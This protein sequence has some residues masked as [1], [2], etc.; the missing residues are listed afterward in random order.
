M[1]TSKR[2]SADSGHPACA[3]RPARSKAHLPSE[4]W[5]TGVSGPQHRPPRSSNPLL[6]VCTNCSSKH[7]WSQTHKSR[8]EQ[9]AYPWQADVCNSKPLLPACAHACCRV[10]AWRHNMPEMQLHVRATAN[11]KWLCQAGSICPVL[12]SPWHS[13][14]SEWILL[15]VSGMRPVIFKEDCVI[16]SKIRLEELA[17]LGRWLK[18]S[19]LSPALDKTVCRLIFKASR[20]RHLLPQIVRKSEITLPAPQMH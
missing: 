18:L 20:E 8:I 11:G 17:N 13:D 7:R 9:Q 3:T 15:T 19:T 5:K 14:P 1:R 4:L 12:L 16:I 10:K 6:L 2:T